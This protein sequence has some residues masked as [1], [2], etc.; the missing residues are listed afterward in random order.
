MTITKNCRHCGTA[1][2]ADEE[3]LRLCGECCWLAKDY[4][5]YDALCEEGYGTY[6]AKLMCG[7]ADPPDPDD[8]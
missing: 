6:Q 3:A 4:K 7:L 5:L 1:L 2:Q 8:K